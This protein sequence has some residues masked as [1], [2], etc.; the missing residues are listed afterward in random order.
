MV[1]YCRGLAISIIL[2]LL[3]GPVVQELIIFMG[4]S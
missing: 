2:C 4:F 3:G 1:F